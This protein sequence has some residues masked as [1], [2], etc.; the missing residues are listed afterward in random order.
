MADTPIT[1]RL[2]I[3]DPVQGVRYSLQQDNAP[4]DPATAG[5][6][7]LSFDV[8]VRL[9]DD[10]RFLGPFVRREG[11][12]RRFVYIRIGTSAGD[13]GS[14]WTRRAKVDIHD[15]PAALLDQARAGRVLEIILPGRGEDGSPACA[16]IHPVQPWRSV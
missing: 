14:P 5:D 6:A 15:I 13:H 3:A 10:N 1:L 4:H 11:P 2:T 12:Q 7:P 16:T 8:S 9:S